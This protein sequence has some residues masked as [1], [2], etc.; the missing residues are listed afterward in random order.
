[1]SERRELVD[2]TEELG[3]QPLDALIDL[4]RAVREPGGNLGRHGLS[5]RRG[6][7]GDPRGWR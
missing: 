5:R 1:M 6:H 2:A 4:G 7:G 3:V